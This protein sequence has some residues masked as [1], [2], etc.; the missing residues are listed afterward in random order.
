MNSIAPLDS[1]SS[2]L[3]TATKL[4]RVLG[5]DGITIEHLQGPID[6]AAKRRNL[7]EY[8]M[9]GCPK[10]SAAEP[11]KAEPAAPYDIDRVSV[12]DENTIK[13]NLG[14]PPKLPFDGAT[15]DANSGDGWVTIEK[16]DNVLY[17]DGVKIDL[18]LDDGQKNGKS[19]QGHKL[20]KAL[21]NRTSVH[22]NIID[23]VIEH[24]LMPDDWKVDES[25]KIHYIFSFAVVYRRRNGDLCVRFWYWSEGRWQSYYYWLDSY[26]LGNYPSAL[27]AS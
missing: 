25:G 26:W 13:V 19:L 5:Q 15:I 2:A 4:L 24:N 6:S 14:A 27:L 20:R 9:A 1:V 16:R 8:L 21:A 3:G 7:K 18:H 17:Q 10:L 22:P 23:A 11:K 12:V